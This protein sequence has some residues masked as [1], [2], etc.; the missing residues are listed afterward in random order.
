MSSTISPLPTG[1]CPEFSEFKQP[2]M[3]VRIENTF[4]F[5][6][7]ELSFVTPN[8]SVVCKAVDIPLTEGCEIGKLLTVIRP[9]DDGS[10]VTQVK[11]TDVGNKGETVTV[12]P[13]GNS[14]QVER[15]IFPRA[16]TQSGVHLK[17]E[18]D[19]SNS[20][21]KSMKIYDISGGGIGATI[22][23]KN[24]V[25][26][27]QFIKFEIE[28]NN[29]QNRIS[30][31][32]EVVHCAL[33]NPNAREYLVGI[34]FTEICESDQQTIITFVNEEFERQRSRDRQEQV[35]EQERIEAQQAQEERS[36]RRNGEMK[37][38][39]AGRAR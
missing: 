3:I 16:R 21:Y 14:W 15:R 13:V 33:R 2:G 31:R 17:I 5:A 34:K 6:L 26:A 10:C 39:R 24:S 8:K 9:T 35:K 28:F 1:P 37:A 38:Q 27:G 36:T 19:N 32:G 4:G 22:Y 11:I 30:G 7:Y 18:F 23:A 12:E 25:K 29:R 20:M